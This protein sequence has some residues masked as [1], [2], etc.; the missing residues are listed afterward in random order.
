[1]QL[2][3][4]HEAEM[5]RC[6]EA[7]DVEGARRLWH[8]LAPHMAGCG[9]AEALASLHMAR[10]QAESIAFRLRAYSHRWLTDNGYPSGLPD[11]MKPKAERIYPTI[12]TTVGISVISKYPQ[13]SGEIGDAMR[14]VVENC[15]ADGK[16]DPE[17][18]RPR[19]LEARQIARRRLGLR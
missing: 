1:M 11:E 6:L 15:Y 10:T 12:V 19:M 9:N 17:Y 3:A 13:V 2:P 14:D 16:E 18:I 7:L 5:R 4:G 8:H